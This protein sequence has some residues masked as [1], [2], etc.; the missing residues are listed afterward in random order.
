MMPD[1]FKNLLFG[2]QHKQD[3]H[4]QNSKKLSAEWFSVPGKVAQPR[5]RA[6]LL[7]ISS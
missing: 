6:P 1:D 4:M 7:R 3:Q 5:V 2:V